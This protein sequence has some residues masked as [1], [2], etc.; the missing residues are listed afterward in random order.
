MSQDNAAKKQ[1]ADPPGTSKTQEGRK[2]GRPRRK[3]TEAESE[4]VVSPVVSPTIRLEQIDVSKYQKSQHEQQVQSSS[5]TN[6]R[7][8]RRTRRSI[9]FEDLETVEKSGNK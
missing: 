3:A 1:P 5:D 6:I 4:P 7:V 8:T 2:A 9:K